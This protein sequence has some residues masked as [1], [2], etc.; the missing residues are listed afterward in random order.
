MSSGK[1]LETGF[2]NFTSAL[3][4]FF[5]KQ[6]QIEP[7]P[8]Y[9]R[10]LFLRYGHL[11]D[12]ILSLPLFLATRAKYPD[13]QIDV[14]CDQKNANPLEENPIVDNVYFYEKNIFKIIRLIFKLRKNKYAYICNLIAYP[15]FTFGIL[16]RLIGPKAVRAAGDQEQFNYFYNR[17]IELPSKMETH[18]LK[19]HFL[20]SSDITGKKISHIKTPWLAINKIIEEKAN[21]LFKK[22][23]SQFNSKNPRLVLVN[24]SAG[25]A[26]REWQQEKYIEFMQSAVNKYKNNIDGWAI[27]TDPKN[28]ENAIKIVEKLNNPSV[29]QVPVQDDFRVMMTLMRKCYLIIT[30]DTSF[31]HAASAMGTPVLN[32]MIGENVLTWTPYGVKYKIVSSDDPLTL[33]ELQVESVLKGFQELLEM[34]SLS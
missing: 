4:K 3:L 15:S 5:L 31:S 21:I 7:T 32:L 27:I 11:G 23:S 24:L 1:Q 22:I 19:R 18:M 9:S 33:K 6:P 17:L 8:P 10:I 13:A 12:M 34:I 25:L 20:L 30:P 28:P 16:A 2:K 14:I 26:R 29:V